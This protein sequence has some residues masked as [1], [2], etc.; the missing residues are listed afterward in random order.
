MSGQGG[1]NGG[2]DGLYRKG[3]PIRLPSREAQGKPLAR[4][5]YKSVAV[6]PGTTGQGHAILLDGRA[7]RTPAKHP[8]SLPTP[9]LAEAVAAEW[10]AQGA[11]INP[12]H[13]PLTRLVNTA[14]DG[15]AGRRPEVAA[16]IVKYAGSDL[17]CYRAQFP[18]G[19]A[20]RQALLW[21]PV[22][23]WAKERHGAELEIGQGIL[24]IAQAPD[25]ADR[26]RRVVDPL[27]AFRLTALHVMT[28]LMGSAVLS[29]A[30]LDERLGARAAWEAAHVDEDWQISEWGSDDEAV[31]R[32]EQRWREM[33]AAAELLRLLDRGA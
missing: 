2:G 24:H 9:A 12:A 7:A 28:T 25:T 4:R 8:L 30:V 17:V 20:Q 3:E 31:A 22:I 13:M 26:L 33:Q 11:E 32:R 14:I 6:G 29:L 16:D 27:D 5:F 23:A 21:D 15:V 19:L 10:A 1:A 18:E